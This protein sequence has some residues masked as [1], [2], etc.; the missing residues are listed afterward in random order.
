MS[1]SPILTDGLR[2]KKQLETP[3]KFLWS[4]AS[5]TVVNQHSDIGSTH[6]ILADDSLCEMI[7][8]IDNVMTSSARYADIVLPGNEQLRGDRSLLSGLCR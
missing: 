4:F 8:V 7:V 6:R 5:N 2:G 3:I 1:I